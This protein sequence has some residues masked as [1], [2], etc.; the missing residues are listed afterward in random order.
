MQNS[1]AWLC[2]RPSMSSC[3]IM[4]ISLLNVTNGQLFQVL[5]KQLSVSKL[6]YK[7][8]AKQD[9]KGSSIVAGPL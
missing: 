8:T 1:C 5:Y 2:Y 7:I 3:P 9:T 4:I 6:I